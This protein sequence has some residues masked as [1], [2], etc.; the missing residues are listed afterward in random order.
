MQWLLTIGQ[1]E[2]VD[3]V[4]DEVESAGG[5]LQDRAPIPLGEQQVVL[6]AEGPESLRAALRASP[7][8]VKVSPSSRLD[9]H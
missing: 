3:R 8:T 1:E 4:R 2:D 9:L 7:L 6:Y 5:H